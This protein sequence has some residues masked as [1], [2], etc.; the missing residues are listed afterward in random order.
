MRVMFYGHWKTKLCVLKSLQSSLLLPADRYNTVIIVQR[1]EPQCREESDRK[2]EEVASARNSLP[3]AVCVCPPVPAQTGGDQTA[4]QMQEDLMKYNFFLPSGSSYLV[5]F[6][7]P[8]D[9][10]M[11]SNLKVIFLFLWLLHYG[12]KKVVFFFFPFCLLSRLFILEHFQLLSSANF[13]SSPLG[14]CT[15]LLFLSFKHFKAQRENP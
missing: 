1:N 2:A 13:Q 8:F 4:F 6:L 14:I 15:L 10:T 11:G 9:L 3:K 5:A 12:G 7:Q